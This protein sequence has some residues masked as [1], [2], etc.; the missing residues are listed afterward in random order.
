MPSNLMWTRSSYFLYF[1]F[2]YD[3]IITKQPSSCS[4]EKN[5]KILENKKSQLS[6]QPSWIWGNVGRFGRLDF[7]EYANYFQ[8]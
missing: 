8:N 2:R 3:V 6:S 7:V 5:F 4:F 1:L